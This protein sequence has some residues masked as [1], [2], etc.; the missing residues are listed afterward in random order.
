MLTRNENKYKTL[1]ET[2]FE[3]R[4]I[5]LDTFMVILS[6]G[7]LSVLA[8][9]RIPLW[10]VPITMQTLGVFM[11][12][13]FFG[14]RKGLMTIATYI[15]AG[16]AGLGVFTGYKSGIATVVGPTGGYLLGFLIMAYFIGR[17]IENGYGR[18]WKS[19]L[20]IMLIGEVIL[21]SIGLT[22]LN[23]FLGNPGILRVLELGLLPFIVGDIIKIIIAI[24]SFPYLWKGAERIKA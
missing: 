1:Y 21:Y 12:A 23:L 19:T 24:I 9:L 3:Y 15:I 6:V 5:Y 17:M 16:I 20:V 14:S 2:I 7:F 13:F 4:N 8:N 10:P 11:I 18:N 22:G